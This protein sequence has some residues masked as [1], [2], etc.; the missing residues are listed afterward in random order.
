M[1]TKNLGSQ[2]PRYMMSHEVLGVEVSVLVSWQILDL[3]SCCALER[4]AGRYMYWQVF[5][6]AHQSLCDIIRE[7]NI[8]SLEVIW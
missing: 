2:K 6:F 4:K 7:M 3:F 8:L 5:T 1:D